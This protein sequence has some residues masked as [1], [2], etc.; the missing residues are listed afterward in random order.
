MPKVV[1]HVGRNTPMTMTDRWRTDDARAFGEIDASWEEDVI[2]LLDGRDFLAEDRRYDAV[3]IHSVFHSNDEHELA[4]TIRSSN[5]F[6]L[7]PIPISPLHSIER[8][9][10][11]LLATGAAKILVFTT[12]P[13]SLDAESIGELPGYEDF[14]IADHDLTIYARR[15]TR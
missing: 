11:R 15:E 9:R 13:R 5:M 14:G 6:N 3:V 4:G 1:A 10:E 7:M 12:W 8:W 2:D